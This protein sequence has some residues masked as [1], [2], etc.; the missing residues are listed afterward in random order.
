ML[1][2][3]E[4]AAR[5]ICCTSACLLEGFSTC[6]NGALLEPQF[7]SEGP[8]REA[9]N[10]R[11]RRWKPCY[12]VSALNKAFFF[13]TQILLLLLLALYSQALLIS[14]VCVTPAVPHYSVRFTL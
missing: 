11:R 3:F 9:W 10:S 13:V 2:L 14:P 1:E 12:T 6:V 4:T 8:R 7:S 5:Q